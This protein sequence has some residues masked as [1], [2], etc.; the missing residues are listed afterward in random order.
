MLHASFEPTATVLRL[1]FSGSLTADDVDAIDPLI[2]G[3]MADQDCE[4]RGVRM[5]YDM[6]AI[7]AVRVPSSRFAQRAATAPVGKLMR[8]IVAPPW[9][10]D[11]NFGSSYRDT[12]GVYS[13][14]QPT[15]VPTL[16][17]GYRLLS[18]SDPRF[19]PVSRGA[20]NEAPAERDRPGRAPKDRENPE[21][22]RD[23]AHRVRVIA[24][25]MDAREEQRLLGYADE[26]EVL[27]SRLGR[28]DP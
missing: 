21:E 28:G 2:V 18:L 17:E 4:D 14:C 25:S 11:D 16:L 6:S 13:H 9:A 1:T 23:L 22:L 5:L 3:V 15:F 20:E 19:R 27:A 10:N 7:D 8:V 26:L 24:A 12:Q